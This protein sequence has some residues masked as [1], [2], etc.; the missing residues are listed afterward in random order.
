M[1]HAPFPCTAPMHRS[2]ALLPC[3]APMHRSHAPLPCAPSHAPPLPHAPHPMRLLC[4]KRAIPRAAPMRR[5]PRAAPM[6][7]LHPPMPFRKHGPLHAPLPS[8]GPLHE[9][10]PSNASR[11]CALRCTCHLMRR[12]ISCVP[13]FT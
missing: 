11:P 9:P 2:H 3:T 5:I 7:P 6:R 13:A 10:L 4:P 12:C 1:Q 8:H